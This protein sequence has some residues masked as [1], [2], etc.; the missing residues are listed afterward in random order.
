MSWRSRALILCSVAGVALA[1]RFLPAQAVAAPTDAPFE[2]S[3]RPFLT[4]NCQRC[5]NVDNSTAGVRVDV[6]DPK[7]RDDQIKM[8]EAVRRRIST[9]TMPPRGQPQPD[10]AERQH[11]TEWIGHGLEVARLR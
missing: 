10:S 8:W 3:I 1:L 7:F 6:L 4:K 11:V 5:H 9:G 2:D